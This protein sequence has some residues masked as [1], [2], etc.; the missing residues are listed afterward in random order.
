[1]I[2]KSEKMVFIYEYGSG[3]KIEI[4]NSE[5][6]QPLDEV[7]EVFKTFLRAVGYGDKL[8]DRITIS[9]DG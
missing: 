1:M 2:L 5:E 6:A 8:I 9:D 3:Y 4:T 7:I